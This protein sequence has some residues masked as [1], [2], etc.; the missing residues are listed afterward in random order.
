[1][2]RPFHFRALACALLAVAACSG[3]DPAPTPTAPQTPATWHKDVSP[4]MQQKCGTCHV[5]GGIA[6]FALQTY[7][8][9][10]AH[11]AAIRSAVQA[12]T[13]PPWPPAADCSTYQQDRSLNDTQVAL[14][15]RW[16]DEGAAEGNPAEAPAP[17][18]PTGGLSRVDVR[19]E[20]ADAYLPQRSPDDYR[21]F[22]IDW[23]EARTRYITGFR[24]DPGNRA[25]VHHV[26]AFL[27][28]PDEVAAYQ[29]LDDS[30]P[31]PGYTCFGGPGGPDA[32]RATW[33]GAW[34]PGSLGQDF[35]EGTGLSIEPGS[36]VIL[37]VHYNDH[38][39][40]PGS[41]RTAV[42]FKV[43]DSVRKVAI[44][45]P[46]AN[47]GWPRGTVP[48]RIPAGSPDTTHFWS[49]QFTPYASSITGGVFQNDVPVTVHSAGL[50]M[51]TRGTRVRAEI[52]RA[53]GNRECILDIPRWDFHWQG[54]YTL[55]KPLQLWNGDRLN[56]ECH[57]DNS[58]PGAT[59]RAWGE[60]TDDEMCL[61]IFYLT[62]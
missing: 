43:D 29:A 48:M 53:S 2:S 21:C 12:R 17:V 24:A 15:T 23:P 52:Q 1:M 59:D 27:A 42:V 51:H 19:L 14:L 33:L 7:A 62:Q 26:I 46:W 4:L 50:H 54:N 37:Q 58:A 39:Q 35:P 49:E 20:M 3:N 44:V 45:Q 9:A 31:G 10:F 61:G 5:E 16:V 38:G 34:A 55:Q 11:R 40:R 60:G 25:T 57:W 47:P 36:K 30:S 22:L 6:P 56:L 18:A 32:T 13:M 41:D 8:D 28:Q